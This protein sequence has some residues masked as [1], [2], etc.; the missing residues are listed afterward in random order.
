MPPG[1]SSHSVCFTRTKKDGAAAKEVRGWNEGEGAEEASPEA[2]LAPFKN[3][4]SSWSE[5]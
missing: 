1:G 4:S 5:I 3:S 2:R